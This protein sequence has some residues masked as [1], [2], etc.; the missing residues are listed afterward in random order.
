MN[1][2]KNLTYFDVNTRVL[3]FFDPSALDFLFFLGRIGIPK[4]CSSP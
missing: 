4:D 3:F 1:I 2:Y